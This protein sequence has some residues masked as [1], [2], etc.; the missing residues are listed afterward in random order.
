MHDGR[1]LLNAI[2][3]EDENTFSLARLHEPSRDELVIGGLC[4]VLGQPQLFLEGP[5]RR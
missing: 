3:R 5:H 1:D 4:R 2:V